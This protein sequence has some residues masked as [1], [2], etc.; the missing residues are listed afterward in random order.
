MKLV[1]AGAMTRRGFIKNA[2]DAAAYLG[3]E[4]AGELVL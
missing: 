4:D 3:V 1:T 2:R